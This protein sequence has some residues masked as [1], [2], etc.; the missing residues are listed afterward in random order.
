[1]GIYDLRT[2]AQAR[3]SLVG[4][5]VDRSD[6]AVE[7]MMA[8][9]SPPVQLL[10]VLDVMYNVASTRQLCWS[11]SVSYEADPFYGWNMDADVDNG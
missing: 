11:P 6:G 3:A 4:S 5:S 1:M 2:A 10:E 7:G 9:M 8:R